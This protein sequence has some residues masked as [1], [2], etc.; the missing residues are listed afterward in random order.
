MKLKNNYLN[1]KNLRQSLFLKWREMIF[2]LSITV[3]LEG[4]N[5]KNHLKD[6]LLQGNDLYKSLWNPMSN[7]DFFIFMFHS[8]C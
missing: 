6:E 7:D 2:T 1:N 4:K 3:F 8:K 5:D